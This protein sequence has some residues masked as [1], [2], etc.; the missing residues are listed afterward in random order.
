MNRQSQLAFCVVISLALCAAVHA[1]PDGTYQAGDILSGDFAAAEAKLNT[2]LAASP[3]DSFA[4]LNLA[5]IYD[6]SGRTDEARALYERVMSL[7][8]NPYAKV[9]NN[10]VV[11][12][13]KVASNALEVL[14]N[15]H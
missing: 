11:P 1:G 5:A 3:N 15:R 7:R 12:V 6:R 4:M 13:K 14:N 10:K 8:D 2:R 9:A